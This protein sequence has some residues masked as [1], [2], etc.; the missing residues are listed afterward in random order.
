MGR[1]DGKGSGSS[2]VAFGGL[3]SNSE[4]QRLKSGAGAA[5]K[6]LMRILMTTSG[7]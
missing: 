7:L 5:A 1:S 6:A 4:M 2:R 3:S